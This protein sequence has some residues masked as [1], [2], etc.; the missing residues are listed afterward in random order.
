MTEQEVA[1]ALTYSANSPFFIRNHMVVPNVFWG[2]DFSYE[3]D[4]L[5]VSR[6]GF[7]TEIEIKVS[8]H[9][10][11]RDREKMHGHSDP[12][13]RQLYF[14][15]PQELEADLLQYA[16]ERAGVITVYGNGNSRRRYQCT[17]RRKAKIRRTAWAF[18]E[19]EIIK[20]L[21]LG[22]MRYWKLLGKAL[23]KG[24]K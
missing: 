10:L 8:R 4:L 22:N 6:N 24:V 19:K 21:R 11:I 12:R 17:I 9:D 14:A 23:A 16:P 13:I 5:S 2:L 20:L 15:G 7:G 1:Y 3:L 18:S